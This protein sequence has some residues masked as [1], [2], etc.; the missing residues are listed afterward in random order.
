M[1]LLLR[2][3]SCDAV[4]EV[5]RGGRIRGIDREGQFKAW[6]EQHLPLVAG[7]TIRPCGVPPPDTTRD[8]DRQQKDQRQITVYKSLLIMV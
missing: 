8:N 5:V 7:I 2:L 6:V 3:K 1:R 4:V